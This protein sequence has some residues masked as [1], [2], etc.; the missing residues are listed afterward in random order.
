[1]LFGWPLMI[2]VSASVRRASGS[3]WFSLQVSTREAMMAQCSAPPSEPANSAFFRL[4][5]IGRIER[6]T[7]LLSS[8][9]RPSSIKYV[10]PFQR[11]RA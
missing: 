9:I 1:M 7:A 8:S 10:R 3:T 6:S 11:E 5:V 4:S 2:L